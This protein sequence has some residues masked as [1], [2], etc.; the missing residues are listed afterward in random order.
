MML[1]N[2]ICIFYYYSS[3]QLDEL[4][5]SRYGLSLHDSFSSVSSL[6]SATN[7][8]SYKATSMQTLSDI[9]SLL[10]SIYC[11]STAVDFSAIEVRLRP[12]YSAIYNTC[13]LQVLLALI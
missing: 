4:N 6:I 3:D 11:G 1:N 5:P 2:W 9:K 8:K 10:E 12:F 7:Y 13:V